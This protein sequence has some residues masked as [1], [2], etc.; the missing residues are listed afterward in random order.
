MRH[1]IAHRK[2][3]RTS[4][5]RLAMKRNMAQSLFEHGQIETTL[6]KAKAVRPFCERLITLAKKAHAGDG[7]ARRRII[8][9]LNDRAVIDE[10][11][12][13]AYENMPMSKRRRALRARSGRRHRRGEAKGGLKFTAESVVHRLIQ[14]VAPMF[15]D[16]DSGYTRVIKVGTGRAGDNSSRAIL[17]LIGQEDS[18]GSVTRP[19]KTARRKRADARYKAAARAVAGARTAAR[20]STKPAGERDQA[21]DVEPGREDAA[22]ETATQNGEEKPD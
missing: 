22:E 15:D 4:E 20:A 6:P 1:R 8:K 12:Q 18:P 19:E 14:T 5:H 7:V 11:H 2:L 10:E 3:N 16:R 9:L 17:Q 13:E 21:P